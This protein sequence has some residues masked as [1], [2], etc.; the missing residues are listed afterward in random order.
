MEQD[1]LYLLITRYL[2]RQT[3]AEE[4]EWLATWVAESPD[5]ERVFEQLKLVWEIS[6]APAANDATAAALRNVKARLGARAATPAPRRPARRP[7][8]W[9][10]ALALLVLIVAGVGWYLAAPPSPPPYALRQT[11]AGQQQTIRL[12]DGSRVTLAPQSRLRY[13]AAFDGA[14]RDVY[15]EGEAFFEVSKDARH[16]FRVHSGPLTTQVLGTKFNVSARGQGQYTTVSLV[17][18]KVQVMDKQNS[19]LLA[20]GQQLRANPATGRIYRQKFDAEQVTGWRRNKLIFKN[21]KLAEAASQIERLYD[22]K[23]VF[24]DSATADVRLWATFDNEPLPAVLDALQLA[25]S[26]TYRREGHVI[27]LHQQAPQAPPKR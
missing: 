13:P 7:K 18:G 15:L 9:L 26:L 10:A 6:K 17:E 20:P 2:A 8:Y 21:E 1:E 23:L 5:H 25:G 19:Y 16:P 4:N 3:S 14:Y 11:P 22:V 12:A 27:Y 24:T